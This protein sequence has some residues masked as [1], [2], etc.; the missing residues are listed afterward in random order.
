[1]M[2]KFDPSKLP[3][4]TV[5]PM[6][7]PSGPIPYL[8]YEYKNGAHPNDKELRPYVMTIETHIDEQ[9]E[10]TEKTIRTREKLE[11]LQERICGDLPNYHGKLSPMEIVSYMVDSVKVSEIPADP[12]RIMV[13]MLSPKGIDWC[14]GMWEDLDRRNSL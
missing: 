14:N 8:D 11:K 2:S 5:I 12:Y 6:M 10:W 4:P 9:K 13:T 3:P 7:P 1:M